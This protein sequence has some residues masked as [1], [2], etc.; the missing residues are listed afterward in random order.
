VKVIYRK[1]RLRMTYVLMRHEL[2][3]RTHPK[4]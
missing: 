2:Y 4:I 3:P 1:T